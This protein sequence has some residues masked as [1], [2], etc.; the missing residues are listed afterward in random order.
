[1]RRA[2]HSSRA[3]VAWTSTTRVSNYQSPWLTA[4]RRQNVSKCQ[5]WPWLVWVWGSRPPG[6]KPRELQWTPISPHN[7]FT[8]LLWNIFLREHRHL[9]HGTAAPLRKCIPPFHACCTLLGHALAVCTFVS[10]ST[11]WKQWIR[12]VKRII[13][14]RLSLLISTREGQGDFDKFYK[15]MPTKA[16]LST[17]LQTTGDN[18]HNI[19]L[20]E[21]E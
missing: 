17:A 12:T 9:Q 11:P 13:L 16:G 1:M 15:I 14:N 7:G 2:T 10:H 6:I 19:L 5:S 20:R 21:T 8:E 4:G 18:S 3:M